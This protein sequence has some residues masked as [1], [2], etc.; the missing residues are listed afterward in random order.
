MRRYGT[1]KTQHDGIVRDWKCEDTSTIACASYSSVL[2]DHH[3]CHRLPP[4]LTFLLP[5]ALQLLLELQPA[6]VRVP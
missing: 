4:L 2:E 1:I 3:Q 5:L 6:S